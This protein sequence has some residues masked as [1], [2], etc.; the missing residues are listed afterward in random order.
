[1]RLTLLHKGSHWGC[2]FQRAGALQHVLPRIQMGVISY[3]LLCC[4]LRL[5]AFRGNREWM[6]QWNNEDLFMI[7]MAGGVWSKCLKDIV[8]LFVDSLTWEIAAGYP[9]CR[10]QILSYSGLYF[11]SLFFFSFF[12][13]TIW[14]WEVTRLDEINSLKHTVQAL[15]LLSMEDNCVLSSAMEAHSFPFCGQQDL[16]CLPP[17]SVLIFCFSLWQSCYCFRFR[18]NVKANVPCWCEMVWERRNELLCLFLH[19]KLCLPTTLSTNDGHSS[20][21]GKTWHCKT[22]E[23]GA[24][25]KGNWLWCCCRQYVFTASNVLMLWYCFMQCFMLW[26]GGVLL[27]Q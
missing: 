19:W 4:S 22:E 1:M 9:S 11:S 8:G 3:K 2:G 21:L 16:R 14:V 7:L 17:L 24:I 23:A 5:Q 12:N 18:Q 6:V 10:C 15:V 20:T 13:A 27:Q 25:K 26:N